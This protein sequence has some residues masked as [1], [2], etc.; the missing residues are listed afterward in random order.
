MKNAGLLVELGDLVTALEIHFQLVRS[1]RRNIPSNKL[2]NAH[3]AVTVK[4]QGSADAELTC[5]K[6]CES[7]KVP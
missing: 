2:H 6:L 4:Y 5:L 7:V 1:V 3:N